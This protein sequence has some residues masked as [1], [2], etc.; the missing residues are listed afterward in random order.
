MINV[1]VPS[2]SIFR[3]KYKELE[4]MQKAKTKVVAA[5]VGALGAVAPKLGE[6]LQKI[7]GT[8]SN[9]S[10]QKNAVLGTANI[11]HNTLK[12]PDLWWRT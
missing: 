4:R 10:A 11:L 2:D 9:L 12:L 1:V 5:L 7:P 3:N 8:T 6:R